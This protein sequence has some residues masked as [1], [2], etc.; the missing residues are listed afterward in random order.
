MSSTGTVGRF[1]FSGLHDAPRVKL[2][3]APY[4]VPAN[5]RS[6]FFGCSRITLT[7]PLF[8]GR[9]VV[10]FFHVSPKSVVV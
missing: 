5:S 6:A 4:S 2:T 9:P 1:S 8:A 3:N 7:M 10:I